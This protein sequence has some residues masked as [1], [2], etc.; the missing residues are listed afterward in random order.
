MEISQA[1]T[2]EQKI[3]VLFEGKSKCSINCNNDT[4]LSEARKLIANSLKQDFQFLD[5]D[6][7]LVDLED[8]EDFTIENILIKMKM[9]QIV[10]N[11]KLLI[12]KK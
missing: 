11:Q 12:K 1:N 5:S 3:N 9:L 2:N 4:H 10:I 7:N 8:E 6:S